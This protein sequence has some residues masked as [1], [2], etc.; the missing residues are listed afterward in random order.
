MM[1]K[2]VIMSEHVLM[3]LSDAEFR[4]RHFLSNF[5]EQIMIPQFCRNDFRLIPD[6]FVGSFFCNIEISLGA[7]LFHILKIRFYLVILCCRHSLKAS[8][9]WYK[10][11]TRAPI[12]A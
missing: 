3:E 6:S 2:I 12:C 11:K 7:N 8:L 4:K 10:S 9:T 1:T 5:E